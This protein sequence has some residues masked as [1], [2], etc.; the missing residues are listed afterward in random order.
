[1]DQREFV[2]VMTESGSLI[3]AGSPE[4]ALRRLTSFDEALAEQP[5]PKDYGWVFFYRFRAAFL[6]GDFEQALRL[7]ECGPDRFT[8]DMNPVNASWMHSAAAEA[9]AELGL[10]D[11][12]VTMAQRCVDLR[13]E[14]GERTGVLNAAA[15]ACALLKRLDRCDLNGRFVDTLIAESVDSDEHRAYGYMELCLN[16]GATGDPARID[17]LLAGQT[18]L[19]ACDH[20]FARLAVRFI[21]ASPAVAGHRAQ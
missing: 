7:A 21:A 14:M 5:D 4:Q 8:A 17:Q 16:I 10:A 1:V 13:L 18:W 6:A 20:D 3:E 11:T 9:A 19:A 15:T 2:T 12:V